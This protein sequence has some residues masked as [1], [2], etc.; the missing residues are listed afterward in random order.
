MKNLNPIGRLITSPLF[1]V[2]VCTAGAYAIWFGVA[3]PPGG[4]PKAHR[5][6][7]QQPGQRTIENVSSA[8]IGRDNVAANQMEEAQKSPSTLGDIA[9][10][11]PAQPRKSTGLG[12]VAVEDFE[13]QNEPMVASTEANA[14]DR[15]QR[16]SEAAAPE[17]TSDSIGPRDP[18]V[19]A[20]SEYPAKKGAIPDDAIAQKGLALWCDQHGL[21][22]QAKVHW[23]SVIRLAPNSNEARKRLGF[24]FRG[25]QWV[26]DAAS[27]E[28]VAQQKATAY[29][30]KELTKFH[31]QMR[32]RTRTAVP[33]RAEAVA[34]VE[35]VGDPRAAAAIWDVF[36]AD[37]GHHGMIV[38]ILKHFHTR[39][40]SE[41]LA[42]MAVYS[43][44]K[45]AQV[46]AVAALTDRRPADFG[47]RLVAL[48]HAPLRIEERPVRLPGRALT[49]ELFVEGDTANFRFLFSR[50]DAPTPGSLEG[51]FQ[52]Q[53]SAGQIELARQ[54][55]ANQSATANAALNQQLN[56][57]KQMIAKFNDSIRALNDRVARVLNEAA[58][59][60]IAPDPEA[61]Q[62][63]LAST[64]GTEYQPAAKRPKPTFTEIVSPLYTPTFLPVP[65]AC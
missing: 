23:E 26:L 63:W 39:K 59:A 32:C 44:D 28:N 45:K 4:A 53:L 33:A 16:R 34:T 50:A 40:A 56:L 55:N 2:I 20:M 46:A 42:A 37:T 24:R 58:G 27:A 36:A 12:N 8:P 3:R 15:R 29:W 22:E 60:G 30:E 51:S 49:R 11:A 65:A 52:P 6:G 57:A 18:R 43:Q 9:T 35:A 21:W 47:E 48:L 41:M 1:A 17:S 5:P 62:R 31:A 19:K 7:G 13:A 61:G 14:A 64:L 38:G 25:G 54:F 10:R